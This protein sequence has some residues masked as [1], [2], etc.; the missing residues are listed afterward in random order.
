MRYHKVTWH[1][2]FP[3]LPVVFWIQADENHD[4]IRKI[5]EYRNGSMDIAGPD[6]ETGRALRSTIRMIPAAEIE[7]EGPFSILEVEAEQ[8][9]ALWKQAL[10]QTE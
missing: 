1:H 6:I 8:F 2:D 4:E 5:E 9:D 3:D 10:E 7:A